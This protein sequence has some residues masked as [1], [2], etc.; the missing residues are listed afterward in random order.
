MLVMYRP[1][2]QYKGLEQL[3]TGNCEKENLLQYHFVHCKTLMLCHQTEFSP[4][5]M[6][7]SIGK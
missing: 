3:A 2:L 1:K 6:N 5:C 4:N 7:Y